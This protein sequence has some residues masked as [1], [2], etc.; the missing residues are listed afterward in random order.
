MRFHIRHRTEYIYGDPVSLCH[1][2]AHLRPRNTDRQT[3]LGMHLSIS[4]EPGTHREYLDFYGNHVTF[5]S[6]QEPHKSLRIVSESDVE[7][8]AQCFAASSLIDSW[9]QVFEQLHTTRNPNLGEIKQFTFESTHVPTLDEFADYARPS[10]APSRPL[11]DAVLD[12]TGRIHA[13]FKF[14]PGVTYVDTPVLDVLK[15]RRGVCQDFAHLE[16]ACLRSIGLAARYVSGYVVTQP[17]PGQERLVGAD[18]SHAWLSVYFPR[19]GWIDFDP[20]TGVMPSD[21]H[22]TLGWGR[23]YDDIGPV[24]GVMLGGNRQSCHVAVDVIPL[25]PVIVE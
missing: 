14:T 19:F 21:Q 3:C 20:T 12:L 25:A 9:D 17:P 4:P 10:F 1:N 13:D 18:A 8:A 6:L 24:R 22:I 5:F 16:I 7:I 2:L 23:D 15:T 11:V